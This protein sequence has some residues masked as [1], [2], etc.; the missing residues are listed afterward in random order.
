M[1]IGDELRLD[2]KN[3]V[4]TGGSRGIG[5]AIALGLAQAGANVVVASRDGAA[6][7]TTAGE[8]AHHGVQGIG[9]ACDVSSEDDLA[10]LFD[11]VK[12]KLGGTD[13]LVCSAGFAKGAAAAD[14]S[15]EDIRRMID[16]HVLG[17]VVASQRAAAQMRERGGGAIVLVTSVWGLGGA[18]GTLPY[19]MAKAALAHAVKVLALEWARDGIRVNGL[20]PGFVTTDMTA[21]IDPKSYEKLIG[22]VP[23]R[24][25]AEPAEMAGPA[26]F[27][28]SPISG[29]VTGH[30]L[31]ADG[32]E[33]A[34]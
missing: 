3:A 18:I 24:R 2:G 19:G 22:R 34:R 16:V 9:V 15:A 4:V 31:V 26:V 27:L 21:Q 25:P 30:V 20:A 7:A 23:M 28:C 33:R 12:E 10:R 32:G 8:V 13:V 5:R 6:C 1:G 29:Y 11:D 14:V 17:S